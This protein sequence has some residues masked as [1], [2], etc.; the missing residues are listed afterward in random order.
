MATIPWRG[1]GW[2]VLHPDVEEIFEIGVGR[3]VSSRRVPINFECVDEFCAYMYFLNSASFRQNVDK[4]RI[5]LWCRG[6]GLPSILRKWGVCR[7]PLHPPPHT[8]CVRPLF[9]SPLSRRRPFSHPKPKADTCKPAVAPIADS[10]SG[11]LAPF[12]LKDHNCSGA[13]LDNNMLSASCTVTVVD[14]E[15]AMGIDW[16]LLPLY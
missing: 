3:K 6:Q 16:L 5:Y 15:S 1:L 9:H 8:C 7:I 10:I 14:P 4:I 13:I 12:C 11:K 2:D